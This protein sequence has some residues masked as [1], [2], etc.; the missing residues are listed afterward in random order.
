[1][2]GSM[3]LRN[4]PGNTR[5]RAV[6]LAA[7]ITTAPFVTAYS[8]TSLQ[9]PGGLP[10]TS[11]GPARSDKPS[12]SGQ[13]QTSPAGQPGSSGSISLTFASDLPAS[14][15]P[16]F[17]VRKFLEADM[18]QRLSPGAARLDWK[19]VTPGKDGVPPDAFGAA[20]SGDADFVLAH[21]VHLQQRMPLLQVAFQAPFSGASAAQMAR[22]M[23]GVFDQVPEM[24]QSF[25][26]RNQV[27]LALVASGEYILA[28]KFPVTGLASLKGRKI[29]VPPA[30]V[31]WIEGTGA[32]AVLAEPRGY[33]KG[34]A[35][36]AYDGLFVAASDI[37]DMKLTGFAHVTRVGMGAM[38]G[39]A[40]AYNKQQWESLPGNVRDALSSAFRAYQDRM[41]DNRV[42]SE[43]KLFEALAASGLKVA[44]L[45]AEDRKLWASRLPDIP[46]Q[47]PAAIRKSQQPAEAVMRIYL[48]ELTRQKTDMMRQWRIVSPPAKKSGKAQNDT[49]AEP[50]GGKVQ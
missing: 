34:L 49:P 2:R 24:R 22:V 5:M 45:P 31:G 44:V 43:D 30:A 10:A 7:A 3:I 26:R 29:G 35:S 41:G 39:F 47:W 18:V 32:T 28:T 37:V 21:V 19:T 38:P 36:G 33:A 9:T 25:L 23:A 4:L 8:Q 16:I 50:A 42:R 46:A 17:D 20:S 12:T 48:D 1:M 40:I 27:L 11:P 6:F 14:A 15:R 13:A